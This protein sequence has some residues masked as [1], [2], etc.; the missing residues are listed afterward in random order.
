[1]ANY[2]TDHPEIEFHLNHPLMKRV[3]DLKERNYVEK[4]QFEDAP[5]NYEDAIENYKRLLDITGDVA[6]NI[7]EPNSEDVDLEGPHL[8]NGRMIY[9]SKTF[10]NLDATRKAGLWGLSMPRRYGG[11]NLPN[12]IFS[13]A[14]E[15]IAA[16]DAGFQNIWSLQSCIDTLYEFGSEEQRQKYIPRICAGETMSMDLT[17]P[18]AGSDLQ[19]VMLKATQDEDGTWRLNG[20]K[21]FITNGDSDIHLVLAR[22]EEGTK[23]GRGLSMFIYDKRDGGVTVRHIEHKLGIHGSPTCELVYKN[24]KAELCGNTRLGLIKYV[25]ALM[26]GAR[27]GIAAQSVGVEQEAYNE[28]LAYAKERAQFGEKIINFPAVYDMLSRM[29]AKL[30][31]GR[32]LLYCCARYVD[33]YKALED[34]ARDTKLTPEERQEMKKYTR[35]ADAFTPLAKGMNSEYANQ[36]AYDAISIH[37]G[38]G[39]IME[40]KCQRLFR[41]ARI[42]SIYEGTTQLQ[43]VA[44]IRYITNGTYLSIIKEMLESE[45]SDDLKALKE[46]V[47][48]LV[49]LYE[50]AINKVK[51]SNDQAVHDFLARRLYNMTGDIVMSLLILDDATK[52]PEMF[53]KSANVYVRMAEEEV[54]GHSAYIQNFKAEDLESFKA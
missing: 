31:A 43:V 30:D 20:V 50:A 33:I 9:A 39:F 48:K 16:A 34:I 37:G 1:M 28:G 24:A 26:N 22:S 4:D 42:F 13:M 45:V 10:E 47:A 40:Y 35:L 15:I 23:D 3:V 46:R 17:E 18:D 2:Y 25:M 41:D 53:Q 11:L 12:A 32:S 38:S 7:I 52:A 6:A 19:R 14:S 27:L 29:K 5:V 51:E 44:A 21:R 54:L 36:N 49:D 8:E